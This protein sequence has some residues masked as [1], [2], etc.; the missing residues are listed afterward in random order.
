MKSMCHEVRRSSPSV[1]LF[2]PTSFCRSITSRIALSSIASQF[3]VV[4]L[5]GLE[6]LAGRMQ[7]GGTSRLPTWSALNG[8][9]LRM[10]ISLSSSGFWCDVCISLH[11]S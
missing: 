5:A 2:R 10:A 11:T 9:V 1:T 6:L 7:L 3:V 8:G 4:D